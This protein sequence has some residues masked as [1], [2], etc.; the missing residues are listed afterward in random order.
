MKDIQPLTSLLD[1]KTYTAFVARLIERIEYHLKVMSGVKGLMMRKTYSTLQSIRPHYIEHILLILSKDY[2]HEFSELHESYR[3]SQSLPAETISSLESYLRRDLDEVKKRF[4]RVT[5]GYANERKQSFI[6]KIYL[7]FRPS[8]EPLFPVIFKEMTS[9]IE[10][11]T[12]YE[13]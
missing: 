3:K 2:I 12:V 9:I 10:E 11:F 4:W 5:D 1:D 7:K 6:G 13:V 8:I